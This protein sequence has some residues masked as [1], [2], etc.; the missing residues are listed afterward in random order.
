MSAPDIESGRPAKRRRDESPHDSEV[1]K[2][3]ESLYFTDG[4]IVLLSLPKDNFVTAF[5]VDKVFLLRSS[6]VFKDMLSLPSPD[7]IEKYD[8][9]P[10]VRL[11]DE[12]GHLFSFLTALYDPM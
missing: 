4:D 7:D 11:Q 5:K 10:L 12:A 1:V 2:S 9:V 3:H 8:G 6:P